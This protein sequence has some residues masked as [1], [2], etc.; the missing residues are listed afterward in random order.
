MGAGWKEGW[1][2]QDGR[3]FLWS[4]VAL[5]L[6]IWSYFALPIE[7][8]VVVFA[9]ATVAAAMLFLLGRGYQLALAVLL[10]LCGFCLAKARTEWV[11]SPTLSASTG[12]VEIRGRVERVER[13]GK[14][15]AIVLA[16]ES[17]GGLSPSAAPS[18]L[19]LA[20]FRDGLALKVGQEIAASGLLQPLP[21]PAAP[22]AYDFGRAL[23]FEGIGGTGRIAGKIEILSSRPTLAGWLDGLRLAIGQRIRAVL[24]DATGAFGEAII[25]GER[26]TMPAVVNDSLQVAGLSH[27]LSISGLHMSLVAG[28]VFYLARA[29][30]ALFPALALAYPIKKWAACAALAAGLFYMLLAG[31]EVATQRSY[32]MLAVMFLAILVD[33]PAMSMRNLAL[34][35]LIVLVLEPEASLT[36][37]FQ[38]SFMAVMGLIALHEGWTLWRQRQWERTERRSWLVMT[39]QRT[40]LALIAMLLT[41]LA[42]GLFSSIPAA[43]HFGRLSPLSL[44]AN[45][46][47]LPIV[48]LIVMP[49]ALFS[50]MLMPLGLERWSLW[51]MG[52]GLGVVISISTWVS[53]LPLA[54]TAV[55]AQPLA[56]VIVLSAGAVGLCLWRGSWRLTGIPVAALGI[57]L[58]AFQA[59]PDILIER[60]AAN[61]ALRDAQGRLAFADARRGRFAAGRWLIANGEDQTLSNAAARPGWSC[62]GK[63]CRAMIKG[64]AVAYIREGIDPTS[65]CSGLDILIADFPLRG[66]CRHVPLRIDRF[67]VWRQGAHAL[68]IGAGTVTVAT[69]RGEQ[70]RRPWTITPTPRRRQEATAASASRR[71]GGEGTHRPSAMG[72]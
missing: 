65:L 42:A 23:W 1:A 27:I 31:S 52:E 8:P 40:W 50:V 38:M 25:T 43:Y 64:R 30:L 3:S 7:P 33:R 26:G 37:S 28:S 54:R 46:L 14:R 70:G 18:R 47:A 4:P 58:G 6:G 53:G 34:A 69:A 15:G 41:T 35:A 61:V 63:A 45:S 49:S 36:A 16:V 9:S 59:P 48:S 56:S 55:P 72:R 10:V 68:W 29:G 13:K 67:D 17:I 62:T 19:R 39:A 66:A 44:I 11:Q 24:P 20:V 51:L 12:M 71:H 2:A 60:M 22:G 21:T 57:A 32:I 5:I